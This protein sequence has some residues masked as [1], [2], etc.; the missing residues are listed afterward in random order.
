VVVVVKLVGWGEVLSNQ[1]EED[2]LLLKKQARESQKKELLK[3]EE[4]EF[5]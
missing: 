4:V 3:W 2:A 1:T 5:N